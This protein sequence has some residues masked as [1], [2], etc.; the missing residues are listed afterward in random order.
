MSNTGEQYY[1]DLADS[2]LRQRRR[3]AH[4]EVRRRR[5]PRQGRRHH[6]DHERLDAGRPDAAVRRDRQGLGPHPGPSRPPC[7]PSRSRKPTTPRTRPTPCC[8]PPIVVLLLAAG[9]TYVASRSIT[10]PLHRLTGDAENM[11]TTGLPETVQEHPRHARSV[12]TWRCPSSP[13]STGPAATRSPRSPRRSTR[14]RPRAADLAVEQAVLRRNIADSFVNLGRRNQNLLCRQLDSITEM[15]RTETDPDELQKLFTLDHL[16]TRMRRNA[17]SLLLLAGLEPHR[18]WSAPGR[19]RS[20]SSAAPSAR[21][22]T[23]SGSRSR[24]LDDATIKGT[25]AA[26]VTHL[27]AELLENALDF[28]P[29]GRT[30]RS[31][32]AGPATGYTLADHRQRHRHGPTTSWPR[33]TSASPARESFTVAPSKY[34]GH[35]VVGRPG[36]PPRRARSSSSDSP[37]GG[38]TACIDARRRH[39]AADET[40]PPRGA[41]FTAAAARPR[42]LP[43][44]SRGPTGRRRGRAVTETVPTRPRPGARGRSGSRRPWPR[45]SRASCRSAP[46]EAAAPVGTTASGYKKRVRGAN[47]PRTDVLSARGDADRRDPPSTSQPRP[48][49]SAACATL[50]RGS[51]S[52]AERA[53]PRDLERPTTRRRADEPRPRRQPVQLD[54]QQLRQGHAA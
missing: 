11:A 32:A 40:T 2:L 26:D 39:R 38:V 42:A 33:P 31:S 23:T 45:C 41:E 34:L 22:R 29:P 43:S 28:S 5:R 50:C 19:H 53:K 8:S 37:D 25:A 20:T 48:R 12:T 27:I 3:E 15:E 46:A 14:S 16:A 7:G 47:I 52:G 36:R 51:Q 54:A 18:Q 44:A 4:A 35:Y 6:D 21:S 30:S 1:T 13:R 24:E 17:E 9:V 49:P 10:R